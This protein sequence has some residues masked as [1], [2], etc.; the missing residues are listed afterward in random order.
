VLS[1]EHFT[2]PVSLACP[3]TSVLNCARVTTSPS[4]S[5]FGIPVAL[6]GLVFFA[7]MLV[8][9]LPRAWRDPRLARLRLGLAGTGVA[10]VIY[11][12]YA[13]LFLVNAI[14]LW[15]TVVHAI[16]VALFAVIAVTAAVTAEG[17]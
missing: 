16:A 17:R 6:L 1:V 10:F 3:A 15:C 12:V 11:L 5:L 8:L 14:C 13:E 2:D 4:A 7:A 9:C